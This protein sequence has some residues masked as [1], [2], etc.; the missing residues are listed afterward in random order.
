MSRDTRRTINAPQP[1][2]SSSAPLPNRVL[3]VTLDADEDV[4]W[5]WTHTTSGVS[6]VSGYTITR[7][8]L[9]AAP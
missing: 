3:A 7:K 4:E 1:S 5:T 2:M 8:R 6:Y 9:K